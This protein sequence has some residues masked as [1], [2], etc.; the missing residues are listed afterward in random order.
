MKALERVTRTGKNCDLENLELIDKL[1]LGLP[2][3]NCNF[4]RDSPHKLL[5]IASLHHQRYIST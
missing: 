1:Q 2:G 4:F 3:C 5:C